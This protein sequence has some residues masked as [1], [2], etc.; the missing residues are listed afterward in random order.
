MVDSPKIFKAN[1]RIN[2]S[3]KKIVKLNYFCPQIIYDKVKKMDIA[4]FHNIYR[5][6]GD[7]PFLKSENIVISIDIGD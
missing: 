7:L 3:M 1:I 6:R 2:K 4:N 5:I